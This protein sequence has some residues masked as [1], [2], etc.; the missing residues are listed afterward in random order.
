MELIKQKLKL[1]VY[2]MQYPLCNQFRFNFAN[3]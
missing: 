2:F 3:L 1:N